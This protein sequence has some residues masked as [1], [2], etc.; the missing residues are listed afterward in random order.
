M[1]NLY[2]WEDVTFREH[3]E[4]AAFA[5]ASS[6]DEALELVKVVLRNRARNEDEYEKLVNQ[7]GDVKIVNESSAFV[8]GTD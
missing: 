1:R 4:G 8:I 3:I 5:F 6:E 2:V 7:L